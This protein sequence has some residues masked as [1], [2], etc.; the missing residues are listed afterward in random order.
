MG[1]WA[2][3]R[4]SLGYD[5]RHAC[6]KCGMKSIKKSACCHD[7]LSFVKLTE[8]HHP[9][10]H[11]SFPPDIYVQTPDYFNTSLNVPI[12]NGINSFTFNNDNSPPGKEYASI[13]KFICAYKI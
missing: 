12:T 8:S 7:E 3:A 1:K 6:G 10:V 2:G 11:Y 9:S 5:N 13:F 4:V